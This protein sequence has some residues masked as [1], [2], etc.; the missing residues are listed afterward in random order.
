MS[1][2]KVR[3]VTGACGSLC[4][5][6]CALLDVESHASETNIA[7]GPIVMSSAFKVVKKVGTIPLE[8]RAK[9]PNPV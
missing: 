2:S 4:A 9:T 7:L 6:P 3:E 5:D 1:V 8:I